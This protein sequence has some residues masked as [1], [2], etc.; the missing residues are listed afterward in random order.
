MSPIT[1]AMIGGPA[2]HTAR[3]RP[4]TS[5]TLCGRIL[6]RAPSI[7]VSGPGKQELMAELAELLA[8][9]KIAPIIDRTY[10]LAEA[11]EAID[12]LASGQAR[13]RIVITMDAR[14][15]A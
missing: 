1:T 9:G 10:P 3:S 4:I 2:T 5:S 7:D 12:Y 6:R 14:A 15:G 8:A 11:P 13:G